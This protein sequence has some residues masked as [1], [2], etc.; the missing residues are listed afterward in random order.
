MGTT[1]PPEADIPERTCVYVL[2]PDAGARRTYKVM[3]PRL[4][5][6]EQA[7]DFELQIIEAATDADV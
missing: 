7:K 6:P 5:H 2:V 4:A 3:S 1:L